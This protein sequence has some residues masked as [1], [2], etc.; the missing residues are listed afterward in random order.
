MGSS[1]E[2]WLK[3]K[4]RTAWE[5]EQAREQAAEKAETEAEQGRVKAAQERFGALLWSALSAEL[6]GALGVSIAH[7]PINGKPYR[8]VARIQYE[9]VLCE[10]RYHTAEECEQDDPIWQGARCVTGWVS[11]QNSD[12]YPTT[13][14]FDCPIGDLEQTLLAALGRWSD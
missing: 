14:S 11:I 4:V 13:R 7:A 2:N 5:A 1:T 10:L 12:Q 8:H 6:I 3:E 9:G